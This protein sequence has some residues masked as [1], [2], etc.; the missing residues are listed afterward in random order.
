MYWLKIVFLWLFGLVNIQTH[1]EEKSTSITWYSGQLQHSQGETIFTLSEPSKYSAE[2]ILPV[3]WWPMQSRISH[4]TTPKGRVWTYRIQWEKTSLT[5]SFLIKGSLSVV[6]TLWGSLKSQKW[7]NGLTKHQLGIWI[8]TFW[9]KKMKCV[10]VRE[11]SHK[12]STLMVLPLSLSLS[13][14]LLCL[15]VSPLC[16]FNLVNSDLI[17]F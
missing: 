13:L 5:Q 12:I 11:Y 3:K 9:L 16:S 17:S 2:R 8:W 6:L 14:S 4:A 7:P 10:T 1:M 15:S